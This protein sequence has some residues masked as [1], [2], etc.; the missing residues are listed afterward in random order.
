MWSG[1]K[2]LASLSNVPAVDYEK[3]KSEANRLRAALKTEQIERDR[4]LE[5]LRT[6]APESR[7]GNAEH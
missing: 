2:K 5:A 3:A 7:S 1:S 6:A 4:N